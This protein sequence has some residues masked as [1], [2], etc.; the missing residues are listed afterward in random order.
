M[1]ADLQADTMKAMSEAVKERDI[2]LDSV[3]DG[4]FTVDAEWRIMSFNRAAERITGVS[5]EEAIGRAC[6]AIFHSSICETDCA[7]RQT[8]TT[9]KEIV[10]KA[11]EVVNAQGE[12]LAISISTALLKDEHGHVIG[13]VETFRDLSAVEALRKELEGRYT[14]LDMLSRNH[15]MLEIFDILPEIAASESAVLIE[16]E[17]GTGKELLARAIHGLSPRADGP[18]VTV[19]CGALPDTLLESELFGHKAGAFTD[20]KKDR[21]GRFALAEGG[22]IFLD[23]VGDTSPAMQVRLLR[24]LQ[25]KVY[26]PLGGT[27]PVHADVRVIAA[28]NQ[29]LDKLVAE[30]RFRQDLYYRVNVVRLQLPP[31]RERK[32]DVPLLVE[33]FVSRFNRLQGKAVA[34]VTG[35][36]LGCLMSHDF[37]GNVREL[38]NIIEHAF[39]LCRGGMIEP[40]HLPEPLRSEVCAA[41]PDPIGAGASL[42]EMERVLIE[43]ALKRNQWNRLRTARE[44]KIARSTLGRKVKTL[45]IKAPSRRG[46]PSNK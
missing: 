39:V 32:E 22:T 15:R 8:M 23:E 33:H 34:G 44:L 12:R 16:S 5:R 11:V 40:R 20:A 21:P 13:G 31:L 6:N 9:G 3:A 26:E 28:T 29:G 7:L 25:E 38:E 4:V 35:K 17:S 19:N 46:R 42:E 36:V 27:E 14:F 10:N 24:V 37:P 2:I 41:C 18:L 43:S 1:T 45:G 30:G